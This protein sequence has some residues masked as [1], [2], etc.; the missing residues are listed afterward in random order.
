[1]PGD[2]EGSFA[3]RVPGQPL[4]GVV[5][6]HLGAAGSVVT[7]Q[8]RVELP[9]SPRRSPASDCDFEAVYPDVI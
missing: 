8:L 6:E 9:Y 7:N 4:Q 5:G 3:E 2:T 1:M